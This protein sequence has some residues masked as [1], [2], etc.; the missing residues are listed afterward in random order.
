MQVNGELHLGIARKLCLGIPRIAVAYAEISLDVWITFQTYNGGLEGS[1]VVQFYAGAAIAAGFKCKCEGSREVIGASV[2]LAFTLDVAD[3]KKGEHMDIGVSMTAAIHIKA[4]G[5][6]IDMDFGEVTIMDMNGNGKASTAR[7][8][9]A[10]DAC[11]C[12]TRRRQLNARR[13]CCY[14]I[15]VNWCYPL[16]LLMLFVA[17]V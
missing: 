14:M 15:N 6:S 5:V 17:I 7:F 4:F 13:C 8:R 2:T 1:A 9:F 11:V 3:V 10:C 12:R 16:V